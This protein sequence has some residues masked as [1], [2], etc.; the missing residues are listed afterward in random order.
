MGIIALASLLVYIGVGLA[1]L[2]A[3]VVATMR[4]GTQLPFWVAA[5]ASAALF[6]F[7]LR[8]PTPRTSGG[9][10][11]QLGYFMDGAFSSINLVFF[12]G[13]L[14]CL[15]LTRFPA[16]IPAMLSGLAWGFLTAYAARIVALMT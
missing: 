6:P 10:Y 15:V 12:L 13:A 1:T 8:R 11:A 4:N 5:V 9:D 16:R 14:A 3:V 7:L 2:V